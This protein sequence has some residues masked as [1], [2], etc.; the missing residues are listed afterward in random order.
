MYDNPN[1]V[2][3]AEDRLLVLKQGSDE[4][5]ATYIARFERV[6]YEARGQAWPDVNKV[7]TFRKGLNSTI[8]S[9][10]AQQ[11]NLPRT[12]PQFLRVV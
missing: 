10:L 1:K 12:Y 6:L 3:E 11:L 4:P 8:R 2:Q 5:V 7:S 9:R